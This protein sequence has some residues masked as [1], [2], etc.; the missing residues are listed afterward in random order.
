MLLDHPELAVDARREAD[1]DEVQ[2][3]TEYEPETPGPIRFCDAERAAL[4]RGRSA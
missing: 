2:S 4:R 1:A 3:F